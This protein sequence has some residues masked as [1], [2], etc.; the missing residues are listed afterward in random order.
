MWYNFFKKGEERMTTSKDS[1]QL[2]KLQGD[3]TKT[4]ETLSEVMLR[5]NSLKDEIELLK[6]DTI[7][8]RETAIED[9]KFLYDREGR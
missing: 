1:P 4:R 9:I 6:S 7:K 5:I 3:L 8:F 2:Q